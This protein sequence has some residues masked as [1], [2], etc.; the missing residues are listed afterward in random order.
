[1]KKIRK[2]LEY[3]EEVNPTLNRHKERVRKLLTSEEGLYHQSH[4]PIEPES[5][6][7]QVKSNK[8]YNRFRHFNKDTAKVLMDFVI[9][10]IVFN[11]GKL[12]NKGKNAPQNA[13]IACLIHTFAFCCVF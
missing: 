2:I 1:L 8:G 13:Q 11:I 9:L 6:F 5:V 7:G 10:A 12:H 4:C 3:I